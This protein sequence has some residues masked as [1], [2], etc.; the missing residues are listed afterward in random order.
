MSA[1]GSKCPGSPTAAPQLCIA[2]RV[3]DCSLVLWSS[4]KGAVVEFAS[5]NPPLAISVAVGTETTWFAQEM[6]WFAVDKSAGSES[7]PKSPDGAAA[8]WL[9]AKIGRPYRSWVLMACWP[10]GFSSSAWQGRL[11]ACA[12]SG[13]LGSMQ[14]ANHP[15]QR[16][17]REGP[18]ALAFHSFDWGTEP[19]LSHSRPP[20][21]PRS[22]PRSR[23]RRCRP[24]PPPPPSP[25]L[26]P[27]LN[28]NYDSLGSRAVLPRWTKMRRSLRSLATVDHAWPR[29]AC[30]AKTCEDRKVGG[31]LAL[32]LVGVELSLLNKAAHQLAAVR[33]RR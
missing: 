1:S 8:A 7:V 5:P 15:L 29:A 27:P 20:R 25:P 21:P 24:P 23:P 10:T 28:E 17:A 31:G 13:S 4:V 16:F 14:P 18:C 12:P 6:R 11:F 9:A 32:D 33:T 2:D 19:I 3:G 26:P 22:R 30:L